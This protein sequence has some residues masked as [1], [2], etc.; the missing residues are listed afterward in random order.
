MNPIRHAAVRLRAALLARMTRNG[1]GPEEFIR[2]AYLVLLKRPPD[3]VGLEGW[4]AYMK[5]GKFSSQFVV[6]VL[7][8]SD[9]YMNNFGG[10][11]FQRLHRARQQWIRTVPAYRRILDIGGSSPNHPEGALLQLGYMHRPDSIDV[12]DLPP[13]QQYW[14]TPE[15][16]QSK[17]LTFDWGKVVYFH[18]SA[19]NIAD[20]APLQDQA[21]DCVFMGQVI[22]HLLPD[23]LPTVLHW[24][25]RHLSSQGRFVFDTPNRTI[26]K[27][28]CPGGFID[29][30]HKLEYTPDQIESVLRAAGFRVMG[31]K[32]MVHLP[33]MARSGIWN[34]REFLDA[35]LLHDDVDNCY[36]FAFDTA[37]D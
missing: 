14:G 17:I 33:A 2:M 19:E 6:D 18:G 7:L 25:R 35:P 5:R 20:V 8:E 1:L 15:F 32:G 27:I 28:H 29:P 3:E 23:Q 11:V 22:E 16:D 21:Y 36:L 24:I 31:K 34:P 9:E 4:R 26:T 37:V 30:D 10:G 12:L 13:E